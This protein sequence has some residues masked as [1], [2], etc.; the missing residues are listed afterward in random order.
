MSVEKLFLRSTATVL[1]YFVF[2]GVKFV[3]YKTK[4]QLLYYWKQKVD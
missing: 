1:T 2:Q 4:T 3:I